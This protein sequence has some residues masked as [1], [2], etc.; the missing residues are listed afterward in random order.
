METEGVCRFERTFCQKEAFMLAPEPSAEK[1][2]FFLLI[3]NQ[4]L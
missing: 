3:I 4:S 1:W 2:V